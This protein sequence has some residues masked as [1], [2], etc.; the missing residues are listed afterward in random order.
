MRHV[1]SA[2]RMRSTLDLLLM[3][4]LFTVSMFS[5]VEPLLRSASVIMLC[6]QQCEG[7]IYQKIKCLGM[8]SGLWQEL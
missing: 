6:Y 4:M 1:S 8:D 7:W 3:P 2:N 5:L